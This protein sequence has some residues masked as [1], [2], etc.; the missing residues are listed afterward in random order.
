MGT[1]RLAAPLK[2]GS[3]ARRLVLAA[4]L[5]AFGAA[6]FI[7]ATGSTLAAATNLVKNGSFEKDSD[8]DVKLAEADS[9]SDVKLLAESKSGP[10]GKAYP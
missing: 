9:D 4:M 6:A 7:L 1:S 8:S 5:C 2:H 10:K 3:K